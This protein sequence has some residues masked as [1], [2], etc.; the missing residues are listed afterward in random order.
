MNSTTSIPS[1]PLI[2]TSV[3]PAMLNVVVSPIDGFGIPPVAGS[4]Y[5]TWTWVPPDVGD[6]LI[7][8][9]FKKRAESAPLTVTLLPDTLIGSSPAYR[10]VR[11]SRVTKPSCGPVG[12]DTIVPPLTDSV[13]KPSEPPSTLA[14]VAPGRTSKMS[15]L[16]VEPLRVSAPAKVTPATSPLPSPRTGHVVSAAGP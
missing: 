6:T 16:P 8:S 2:V 9:P 12:D 15:L 11:P 7:Q 3:T 13:S 14:I 4:K 1:P 10:I 5:P